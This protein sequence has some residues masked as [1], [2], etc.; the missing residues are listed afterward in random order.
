MRLLL[1]H[2]GDAA[3]K[4]FNFLLCIHISRKLVAAKKAKKALRTT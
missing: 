3:G 4:E 2:I 1:G